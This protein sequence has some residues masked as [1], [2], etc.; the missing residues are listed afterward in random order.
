M[1]KPPTPA[2][3][4]APPDSPTTRDRRERRS[5]RTATPRPNGDA[6]IQRGRRKESPQRTAAR[7]PT[8]PPAP[9]SE[10]GLN[11]D[12]LEESLGY[13]F[14]S[15]AL[16]QQA[17]THRSAINEDRH[18]SSLDSYERME[19]LG[20]S[21]LNLAA[22]EELYL[23]FPQMDEGEMTNVRKDLVSL[24]ALAA[25][26]DSIG[27]YRYV[28]VGSG[29]DLSKKRNQ[30]GV[31]GRSFEAIVG[32]VYLDSDYGL[33]QVKRFLDP[34]FKKL[35][36]DNH[37]IR[38]RQPSHDHSSNGQNYTDS[39]R[40]RQSP[41]DNKSRLQQLTQ[42][43]YR[44]QP[45]YEMIDTRGPA[46]APTFAV[47]VSLDGRD[48]ATATGKTMRGAEQTAAGRALRMLERES[49]GRESSR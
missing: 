35:L 38:G 12:N 30:K 15:I 33:D 23:R 31:A 46:H 17:L 21:A 8:R 1:T 2:A 28:V 42:S 11:L 6:S 7:R 45:R 22:T 10:S 9:Q 14:Q 36:L 5:R 13:R 24:T 47:A 32:A 19:F 40:E 44:L 25:M 49:R 16:L 20:D 29:L 37:H 18:L 39:D 48:L 27:L 34:F 43:K 4:P 26:A 41:P 3:T